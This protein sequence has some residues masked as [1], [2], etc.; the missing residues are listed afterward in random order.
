MAKVIR[1]GSLSIDYKTQLQ[2]YLFDTLKNAGN[3]VIF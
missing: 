3:F 1:F 2:C